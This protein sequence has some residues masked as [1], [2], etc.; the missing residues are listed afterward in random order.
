MFEPSS[1]WWELPVHAAVIYVTAWG[2][3]AGTPALHGD[4]PQS[5][6]C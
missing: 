5:L 3:R 6:H 1:P 2:S 4:G